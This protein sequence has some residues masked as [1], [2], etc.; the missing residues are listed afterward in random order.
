[1]DL[2]EMQQGSFKIFETPKEQFLGFRFSFSPTLHMTSYM[3][4]SL[5]TYLLTCLNLILRPCLAIVI[6]QSYVIKSPS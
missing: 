3:N 4:V 1:M 5:L 2:L 6:L